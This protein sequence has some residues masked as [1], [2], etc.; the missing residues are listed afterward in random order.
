MNVGF[1]CLCVPGECSG[2]C[3]LQ[4]D[5]S[6]SLG[7]YCSHSAAFCGVE[8]KVTSTEAFSLHRC[9]NKISDYYSET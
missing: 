6:P 3:E 8:Y 4:R 5:V 1:L 7:I 9:I 2:G